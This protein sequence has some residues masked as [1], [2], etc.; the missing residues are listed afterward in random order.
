MNQRLSVFVVLLFLS[1]GV[2]AQGGGGYKLPPQEIID[3]VDAPSTPS[4]NISPA[5]DRILLI[6]NPEMPSIADVAAPE[7]RLGGI[8]FNPATNGPSRSSYGTAMTLTNIDGKN[9]IQVQGLPRDAKITNISW[10]P[11]ARKI[12]FT[13]T[14]ENGLEL[15]VVDVATATAKRIT[16][17]VINDVTRTAIS[18]VSDSQSLVYA[19]VL[20]N[21]GPAPS[22][23][24]VASGPIIQESLGRRAAVRTFQDL[25]SDRYDEI[26]F[27]YYATSQLY[28]TD[29]EGKR[30]PIGKPGVI[31]SFSIS[32]DGNY[33]LV[34]RVQKPYSYILP[35]NRFPQDFELYDMSGRLVKVLAQIPLLD[36]MPQGRGA[37]RKGPRS[38]TWRADAPATIYW[39]EA[40]DGGDPAVEA[41]FRD[42]LFYLQAP[43]KG[44]PVASHKLQYRYSGITWGRAD[45]AL[46]AQTWQA[47]RLGRLDAFNPS[48]DSQALSLVFERHTEDRYNDPGS[49][50]TTT[51]QYGRRV[52]QFDRRGR[53]LFLTGTGA[54]PEGNRPFLDEYDIRTGK[55]TRLWRSQAPYYENPV[56]LIDTETPRLITRRESNEMHPNFF[57]RD[58]RRNRLTQITDLPDPF[59]PLRNVHKEMI[60]Y[61]R[62]DG[63]PLTGVLYLPEGYRIGVDEP[64]PTMLWAYPR[65]F[66][67]ADA[68]G[69]VS[70]SPHT[71]T[72]VGASS[73]VMLITQGYAV[74][75]NAS[76]PIIGEGD[77]EPNDTF[78]EQLVANAEAAIEK[79][80][81]MGVTD[82]HR[83]AVSG[84]SYGAFMT[85]NLLS[86]SNLFAAGIA[87]SGAYNRTLTPFGFQ[88][89]ERTYWQAPEVY[90]NMS[91]FSFAHQMKTPMLIIHGSDDN[92]SGTF[93]IQSERYYDALRGQGATVRLVML[94]HESHGYQ[95]RESVLHMHHE[96]VEWLNK[97]VKNR[98]LQAN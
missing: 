5:N 36:E 65:E 60:H 48:D 51:N 95:A 50:E 70:G 84:H 16:P 28:K 41:P 62:K 66:K 77:A 18:W 7:L 49:F 27:D 93:P 34:N 17:P 43:F 92:N 33:L 9:A 89:E 25:I 14:A 54:S 6:E 98:T 12:A 52:L 80:V 31:S 35:Y 8:R 38:Y 76:F 74:L 96:W 78:V 53:K 45:Y 79:L 4:M 24:Q 10:S 64:L 56:R 42:Q 46:I 88:A 69:Q 47:D 39:V 22:R 32:P 59:A 3:L 29:L 2:L 97:Y 19:S 71:Y 73:A 83:V 67:S 40:L 61:V 81:E 86:H 94:P 72:R 57:L 30:Q 68:A 63:V 85:A 21:R 87:R 58:V 1:L 26:I 15:W 20:E 23:P 44:Q 11:D 90:F 91:P 82:R 37:T 75:D 13:H 55:V